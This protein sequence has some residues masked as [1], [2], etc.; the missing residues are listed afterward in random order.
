[1]E[2]K[3]KE[4][5]RKAEEESESRRAIRD[6]APRAEV[7]ATAEGLGISEAGA[8]MLIRQARAA[9]PRPDGAIIDT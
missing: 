2:R 6:R 8:E 3:R 7:K 9:G 5:S 4:P 1:V